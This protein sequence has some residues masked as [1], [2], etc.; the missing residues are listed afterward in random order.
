MLTAK[1]VEGNWKQ[2]KSGIRNLWRDVTEE[3]LD[4]LKGN[5]NGVIQ[6]VQEKYLESAESIHEKLDQ[7]M[8]SFDNEQD[9]NMIRNDH[10][11][12]YMRNPT[13]ERKTGETRT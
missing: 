11:T 10:V 7:L 3:D 5:L 13:S 12:S 2:I 4:E 6:L 8:D 1:Q 9:R